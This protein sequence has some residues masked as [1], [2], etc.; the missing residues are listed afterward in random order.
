MLKYRDTK[1][2]S[3]NNVNI[4]DDLC[5]ENNVYKYL[6]CFHWIYKTVMKHHMIL[7]LTNDISAIWSHVIYYS[8]KPVML[9]FLPLLLLF[10]LN[11][12]FASSQAL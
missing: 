5:R 12:F 8:N 1:H 2:S 6:T 10:P 7:V 9:Y 4:T 11:H 3:L